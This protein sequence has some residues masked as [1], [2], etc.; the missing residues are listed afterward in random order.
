ML[1]PL[2]RRSST[3]AILAS[4]AALVACGGPADATSSNSSANNGMPVATPDPAMPDPAQAATDMP[5]A[6]TPSTPPVPGA[7]QDDGAILTNPEDETVEEV[8]LTADN[9]CAGV[10]LVPEKVEVEVPHEITTT[11]EV[12]QPVAFYIVLDNS[13]SMDDPLPGFENNNRPGG[14]NFTP[15]GM[16]TNPVAAPDGLTPQQQQLG[17]GGAG[18]GGAA[19]EP[20]PA[21]EAPDD[22]NAPRTRWELAVSSLQEFVSSPDSAGIDVAIQYFNP[23]GFGNDGGD[24]C[25]GSF[26]GTPDVEMGPL[27]D[28]AQ[29]LIDSLDDAGPTGYTPTVGALTG[30]IQYCQAF[31]EANPDEKC[32]VVLVTDGLPRS[33]GLCEDG[34]GGTDCYDPMSM[35]VLLPIAQAGSAAGVRT[36]TVVMDGV[37]AEGFELMDAIAL[38]GGTDCTPPDAGEE[39]C[40]VSS[41]GSQGLVEALTSIRESVTVTE[42]VIETEI[43]T[44]TKTLDCQ[45]LVPESTDG[46]DVNPDR[47]NVQLSLDGG[48]G[49]FI[50]AV[51]TEADCATNG[52]H[53]WYYDNPDAPTTIY[54]CPES[55]TQIQTGVN[56]TVQILLG[57]ATRIAGQR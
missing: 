52:G 8:E 16:G 18:V 44:E 38:A 35:D 37:P 11:M 17:S 47:V 23:S 57:C 41:T 40:N 54:A 29:A 45:W 6:Q 49:Q 39:A 14:G 50:D 24:L 53:G 28:N 3:L 25:D 9:A 15:P 30:G 55:C 33:C 32:L 13:L 43:V 21:A 2:N 12:L 26:H 27:P 19:A 20:A 51:P 31:Q 48:E 22:P 1:M 4:A 5:V 34:G 36:F 56:P 46:E 10:E 7:G 42:T